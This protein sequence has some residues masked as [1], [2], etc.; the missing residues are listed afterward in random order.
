[1]RMRSVHSIRVCE[2]LFT[3]QKGKPEEGLLSELT[4]N[5]I[6]SGQVKFLPMFAAGNTKLAEDSAPKVEEFSPEIM[7]GDGPFVKLYKRHLQFLEKTSVASADPTA[8]REGASDGKEGQA[9]VHSSGQG[10]PEKNSEEL[11]RSFVFPE[12]EPGTEGIP[13]Q[14]EQFRHQLE[15]ALRRRNRPQDR[16]YREWMADKAKKTEAGSSG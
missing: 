16:K 1:M 6:R 15:R 8:S 11:L 9:L 3:F 4:L 2:L 12:D 10:A 14:F 5:M 7:P 13:V